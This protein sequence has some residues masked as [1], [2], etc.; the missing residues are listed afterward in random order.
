MFLAKNKNSIHQCKKRSNFENYI[1]IRIL[2]QL[3]IVWAIVKN[4]L[5]LTRSVMIINNLRLYDRQ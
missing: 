1:E 4:F 5:H 3:L 2:I